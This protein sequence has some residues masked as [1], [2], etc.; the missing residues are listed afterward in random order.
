MPVLPVEYSL[1][2][3]GAT[4]AVYAVALCTKPGRWFALH[5]T[6]WSVVV[7]VLLVVAWFAT[8]D[9]DAAGWMLLFFVAGGVPMIFRSEYLRRQNAR[10]VTIYQRDVIEELSKE[11]G[12][13]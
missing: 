1:I 6:E 7:G 10:S 11:I 13:E 5:H 4:C 12:G 8:F 3:C 9:R 2:G